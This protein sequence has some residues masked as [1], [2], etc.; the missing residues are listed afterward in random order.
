MF[1]SPAGRQQAKVS[2]SLPEITDRKF[3][4]TSRA[5]SIVPHYSKLNQQQLFARSSRSLTPNSTMI[6]PTR[7][8]T[9]HGTLPRKSTS[10][11]DPLTKSGA[12][13]AVQL[14]HRPTSATHRTSPHRLPWR[15]RWPSTSNVSLARH[16]LLAYRNVDTLRSTELTLQKK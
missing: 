14:H 8:E 11:I 13:T 15:S 4:Q 2:G 7:P 10:V 3:R 16:D 5:S 12:P 9:H 6:L 1:P